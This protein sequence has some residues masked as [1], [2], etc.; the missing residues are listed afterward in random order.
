MR[1]GVQTRHIHFCRGTHDQLY[2]C[3]QTIVYKFT[4]LIIV[5]YIERSEANETQ[6]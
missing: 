1:K 4:T 6:I 5:G 2:G 3:C